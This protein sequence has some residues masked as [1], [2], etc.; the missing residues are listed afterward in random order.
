[1]PGPHRFVATVLAPPFLAG[2]HVDGP[3]CRSSREIRDPVGDDRT[4]GGKGDV[5]TPPFRDCL[6]RTD[7]SGIVARGDPVELGLGPP[8]RVE[9]LAT[10]T[11]VSR[12]RGAQASAKRGDASRS[13][14]DEKPPSGGRYER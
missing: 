7:R 4:R 10:I 6:T 13:S 8:S 9:F 14:T 3:K 5:V 1:M 2:L 11:D 12:L